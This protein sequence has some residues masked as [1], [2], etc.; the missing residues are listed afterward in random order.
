VGVGVWAGCSKGGKPC[1]QGSTGH[2]VTRL[3]LLHCASVV[4]VQH[5]FLGHQQ[6]IRYV[7]CCCECETLQGKTCTLR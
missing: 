4:S 7:T 6:L 1:V 5:S 3:S 2:S